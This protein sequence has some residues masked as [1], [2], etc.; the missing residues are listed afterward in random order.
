M[1]SKIASGAENLMLLDE[2]LDI[3]KIYCKWVNKGN[4]F[5]VSKN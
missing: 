2:S 1:V 3:K 4:H 5:R